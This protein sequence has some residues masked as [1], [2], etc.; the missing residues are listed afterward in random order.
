MTTDTT[1]GRPSMADIYRPEYITD[2]YP[3]YRAIREINPV[4]WDERGGEDGAWMV[5]GFEP[6]LAAL[7][8]RRLSAR[9]PQWDPHDQPAEQS[10]P[11]GTLHNQVFVI[12]PPRHTVVRKL[13]SKPFLP[14]AVEQMR[15]RIEQAADHL[16]DRVV[17]R[18]EMEV[19]ADYALALP[20]AVVSGVL[21]VPVEDQPKIWR[22]ILSW[23]LVVDGGPPSRQNPEYHLRSIGK[24]MEYFREQLARRRDQRTDDLLQTLADSWGEGAWASEE[25]LLGNLIFMLTAGQTTTAHQIG[26]TVLSL[27]AFPEVLA[28]MAADPS[29]VVAATPEFMRYDS[30][31]QLTKRRAQEP[32]ELGGQRIETGQEILVWIGAAHR[33][34]VAFP[35]PDVLDPDR[36]K[37]PNLSLGH[38]IHYCLGGQLGQLVN[39]VAITRFVDRIG[40]PRVDLDKVERA[41]TPTFRGPH[42]LPITFG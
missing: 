22:R 34:P 17:D 38:G 37:T 29:A 4:Y 39:E 15:A 12:D 42:K 3:L 23:G 8:D 1:T 10:G 19:M 5:T 24:Y 2:P 16:L 21:G 13:L 14:R 41:E 6:A 33:D 27:M 26:N 7:T 11:L 9:R 35:D 40:N 18:G 20:G 25:E 31:V 36:P 28:R 32:V 30:S